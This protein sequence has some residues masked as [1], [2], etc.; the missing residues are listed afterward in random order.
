LFRAIV[1]TRT[2]GRDQSERSDEDLSIG[3]QRTRGA[4]SERSDEDLSVG[5]KRRWAVVY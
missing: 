1:I 5:A 3:A 4:S 2:A